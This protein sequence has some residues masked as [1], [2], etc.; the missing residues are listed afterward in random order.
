M[1]ADKHT[2][3]E[4]TREERL[5]RIKDMDVELVRLARM[6]CHNCAFIREKLL[7]AYTA[8]REHLLNQKDKP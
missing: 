6:K 7:V 1:N 8:I 3:K 5:E 2:P 4:F